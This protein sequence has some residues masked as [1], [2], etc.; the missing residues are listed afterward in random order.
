MRWITALLPASVM[1]LT[2]TAAVEA[3]LVWFAETGHYYE[4]MAEP[5]GITWENALA[6]C[7][8]R[9]GYLATIASATENA[10]VFNL[11]NDPA[12]WFIDGYNNAIGPWIGGFQPEGSPEPG[13]NWQWLTGEP[14]VFTNWGPNEPNNF[15][16]G[17]DALSYFGWG[18]NIGSQWNDRGR[19]TGAAYGYV[20]ETETATGVLD[21]GAENEMPPRLEFLTARPN[22]FNPVT[23]IRFSIQAEGAVQLA[24]YDIGGR[25]V[26]T[27]VDEHMPAGE[28]TFVWNGRSR[29]GTD[30]ASGSYFARL[31]VGSEVLTRR[32]TL[33]R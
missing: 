11:I 32:I 20:F 5:D 2:I 24:L 4:A 23:E 8:A 13:G 14:W 22:P 26:V 28:H 15:G 7:E 19:A 25:L 31:E 12:F 18:G 1:L 30:A 6:A 29:T 17:E 10:F 3:E 33:V 27:L 21:T 16:G 9:G